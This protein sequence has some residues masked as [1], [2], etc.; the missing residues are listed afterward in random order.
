MKKKTI[1][2][3]FFLYAIEMTVLSVFWLENCLGPLEV[4]GHRIFLNHAKGH[5]IFQTL[6]NELLNQVNE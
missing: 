5:E 6:L 3:V 1:F 4:K 2:K